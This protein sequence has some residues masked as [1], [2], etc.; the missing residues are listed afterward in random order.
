MF[1]KTHSPVLSDT[2]GL[3]LAI[4]TLSASQLTVRWRH[5]FEPR[6]GGRVHQ[7]V[8]LFFTWSTCPSKG[9][10]TEEYSFMTKN[11]KLRYTFKAQFL[12]VSVLVCWNMSR[13]Q[14]ICGEKKLDD[15][16]T[17]L[18]NIKN[19]IN[20]LPLTQTFI[21]FSSTKKTLELVDPN[22]TPIAVPVSI[23]YKRVSG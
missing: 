17:R 7:H 19:V 20:Y 11:Q 10:C 4:G 5:G 16:C 6:V 2:A 18:K 9:Q 13:V 15:H 8:P 12:F 22:C 1:V 3:L 23:S 21:T 14:P